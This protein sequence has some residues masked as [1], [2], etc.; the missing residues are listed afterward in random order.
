MKITSYLVVT[1]TLHKSDFFAKIAEGSTL[2]NF[3]IFSQ[4]PYYIGNRQQRNLVKVEQTNYL[5][6]IDREILCSCDKYTFA[7][8]A[9]VD[10]N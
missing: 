9:T 6:M 1:Y 8:N 4:E 7:F 2:K 3:Y 5:F 10:I